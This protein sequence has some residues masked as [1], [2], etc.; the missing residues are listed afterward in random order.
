MR[1]ARWAVHYALPL[2]GLLIADGRRLIYPLPVGLSVIEA[3][4]FA[5]A[6][7][8]DPDLL[9]SWGAIDHKLREGT[10]GLTRKEMLDLMPE[11]LR[12]MK[13]PSWWSPQGRVD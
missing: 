1:V 3:L 2:D 4:N 10:T 12:G 8:N 13:P 5:N 6:K 11:R 9:R 7:M